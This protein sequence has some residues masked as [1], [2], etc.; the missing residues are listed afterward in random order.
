MTHAHGDNQQIIGY[1][2][3]MNLLYHGDKRDLCNW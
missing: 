2:R 3:S 1:L